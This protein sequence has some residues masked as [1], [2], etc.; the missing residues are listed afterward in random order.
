MMEPIVSKELLSFLLSQIH[1]LML[2]V[3]LKS[4]SG[5]CKNLG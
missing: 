4:L 2:D 3:R 5:V 1:L